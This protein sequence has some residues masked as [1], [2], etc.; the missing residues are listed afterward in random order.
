MSRPL[1]RMVRICRAEVE[2]SEK[3]PSV[4]VFL[5]ALNQP[6]DD[7]IETAEGVVNE[8]NDSSGSRRIFKTNG[9]GRCFARHASHG[10]C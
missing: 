2:K 8:V 7:D 9:F 10:S 3:C 4:P 5:D 6:H 1:E